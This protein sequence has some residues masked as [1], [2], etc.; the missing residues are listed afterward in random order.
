MVKVQHAIQRGKYFAR[1]L[2]GAADR[3]RRPVITTDLCCNCAQDQI[4]PV[5]QREIMPFPAA[6]CVLLTRLKSA[7]L[8][9]QAR[10]FPSGIA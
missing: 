6:A 8:E 4:I 2:D 7:A 9:R 5:M 10:L 3:G 1:L